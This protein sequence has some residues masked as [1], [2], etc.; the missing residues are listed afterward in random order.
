MASKGKAFVILLIIAVVVFVLVYVGISLTSNLGKS[1]TEITSENALKQ[2]DKLYSNI[3]VTT[4]EQLKGQIDLDPV[5]VGDSLPDI[6]KFPISVENT[7]ASFVE[8]FSSTEKS[9]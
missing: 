9:G 8:I 6:S 7:S 5:E 2:L 1:D 4:A 3:S